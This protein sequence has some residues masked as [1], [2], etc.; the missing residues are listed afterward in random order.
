V[1]DD[2]ARADVVIV[3]AGT[4]GCVLAARLSEVPARRVVLLEAGPGSHDPALVGMDYLA[5][6]D[7][8]R[9]WDDVPV[10]RVAG[11]PSRPYRSGRG[12]GG[13]A[14]VNGMVAMPPTQRDLEPWISAG[15]PDWTWRAVAPTVES[16]A[17]G[18]V[19]T[20]TAELG[21]LERALGA[22][23]VE[24]SLGALFPVALERNGARRASVA[25]RVLGPA[26]GRT[27]LAVRAAGAA[28]RVLIDRGAVAGVELADGQVVEAPTVV[29]AAGAIRSPL[30]LAASGLGDRSVAGRLTDHPSLTFTL[31]LRDGVAPSAFLTS[32]VVR[33]RTSSGALAELLPIADVGDGLAAVALAIMDPTSSGSIELGRDGSAQVRLGML[34]DERDRTAMREAIRDA[35]ALLAAPSMADL[36]AEVRAGAAG[37]PAVALAE[38]ADDDLDAA[39]ALTGPYLHAACSLPMGSVLDQWGR[40]PDVAGLRVVDASGLPTLPHLAPNGTVSVVAAHV[41]A[42]WP[43]P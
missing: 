14:A 12:I 40:V 19:P 8:A 33:W 16:L 41:A 10:E 5:P 36:V 27:N 26:L 4:A 29:V 20:A 22:A 11:Q 17:A 1:S 24:A 42:N 18:W 31:R 32:A 43:H 13:S 30:L 6:G 38:A 23:T 21:T 25:E 9:F 35:L 37:G 2:P 39:V 7:R 15:C 3:G 28:R 34:A